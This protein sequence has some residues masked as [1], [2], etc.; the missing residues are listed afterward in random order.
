MSGKIQMEPQH[1][2]PIGFFN[3][4][5]ELPALWSLTGLICGFL[6]GLVGLNQAQGLKSN[7]GKPDSLV[8]PIV[9]ILVLNIYKPKEASDSFLFLYGFNFDFYFPS[10]L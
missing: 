5:F 7:W 2:L 3:E 4:I 10:I 8:R 6:H 9:I 1:S